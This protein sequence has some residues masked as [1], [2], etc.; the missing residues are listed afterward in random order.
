MDTN[1]IMQ[2]W[3]LEAQDLGT[4]LRSGHSTTT[5]GVHNIELSERNLGS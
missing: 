5:V 1:V 3:R 4:L 2:D